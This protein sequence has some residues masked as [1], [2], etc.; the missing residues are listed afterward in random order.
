MD[1]FD[2][3]AEKDDAG[4]PLELFERHGLPA[5]IQCDNG[6]PFVCIRARGGLT[7]LSAWLIRRMNFAEPHTAGLK[8]L[9][10][11]DLVDF[12]PVLEGVNYIR[13]DARLFFTVFVKLGVGLLGA[14]NVLLPV[15]GE[16]VFPVKWAGIDPGRGAM[17][18]MSL[19]KAGLVYA[20]GIT[21]VSRTYSREI[22]TP[23]YG[24]GLEGVLAKRAADLYGILNGIDYAEW[25]PGRRGDRPRREVVRLA[26]TRPG[27]PI[28]EV[29]S[30]AGEV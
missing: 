10:A 13:R 29:D 1:L 21:T 22:Q 28:V 30:P 23:E 27:S 2:H 11:R 25:N 19:L 12:K 8:P 16:R 15:L 26:R 5:T 24:A 18:G 20:D 9:C 3:A 14:N 7:L 4:K 17:L 6:P